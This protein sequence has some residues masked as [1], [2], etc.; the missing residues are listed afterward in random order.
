MSVALKSHLKLFKPEGKGVCLEWFYP[1]EGDRG[2]EFARE[3]YVS[4]PRATGW[5]HQGGLPNMKG[6]WHLFEFWNYDR[7]P[8]LVITFC[9]AIAEQFGK[10]LTIE[11]AVFPKAKT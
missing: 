1:E 10:T 3:M 6:G 11:A 7:D 8:E 9:K 2:E 5:F 4:C